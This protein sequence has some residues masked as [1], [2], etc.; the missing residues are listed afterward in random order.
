LLFADTIAILLVPAMTGLILVAPDA[1]RVILGAKWLGAVPPL[2]WLACYMIV[3]TLGSL[4][5]QVLT[6]RRMTKMTMRVALVNLCIM[7]IAFVIGAR[8]GGTAGVA[9]AWLAAAPLTALPSAIVL[10]RRIELGW[11]ECLVTFWP[12]IVGSAVMG[13]ALLAL[14]REIAP[15]A[16][17]PVLRLVVQIAA[18]AVVYSA[19]LLIFFREK[20]WRYVRFIQ[21][22]RS[23]KTDEPVQADAAAVE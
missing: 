9:A 2:I 4:I 21:G 13:V 10:L 14:R 18:G 11:K 15:Y 12:T 7:P 3:S 17:A 5:T 20:V 8:L 1:V 23:G 16:L 6:S 22:F 19:M